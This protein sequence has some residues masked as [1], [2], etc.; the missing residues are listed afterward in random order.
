MA[1]NLTWAESQTKDW[2]KLSFDVHDVNPTLAADVVV[3]TIN[4]QYSAQKSY[5][6]RVLL[7]L[8]QNVD[9][10]AAESL[11]KT[12][13]TAEFILDGNNL[14]VLNQGKTFNEESLNS[15]CLGHISPKALHNTNI[16][17][18]SKGIGFRGTLNWSSDIRIYSGD[19]AVQFSSKRRSAQVE[20][21]KN[22]II[23]QHALRK[24]A[25]LVSKFPILL[26]PGNTNFPKEWT[27]GKYN[28]IY[29]TCIEII[30][31]TDVRQH[32][33][34]AIETFLTDEYYSVLFF[35]A[36][37]NIIFTYTDTNGNIVKKIIRTSTKQ[38][39]TPNHSIKTIEITSDTEDES[40]KKEFHFFRDGD[41]MIAV[42]VQWDTWRKKEYKLFCT[43]PTNAAFCPFP[44]LMNSYAFDVSSDRERLG[45]SSKN[46]TIIG[47]L[48][49]MLVNTVAPYYAN[50]QFG[51]Q[52]IE[53]LAYRDIEGTLFLRD[54]ENLYEQIAR[55]PIIPTLGNKYRR[56]ADGL[57]TMIHA[58]CP[59]VIIRGTQDDFISPNVYKIL[60]FAPAL[61]EMAPQI[62]P[63]DLYN[64]I[65][66]K[67]VNWSVQ[68][69]VSV[70]FF[71]VDK[72]DIFI[73]NRLMPKLIKNQKGDFYYFESA[74]HE[75][76]YFH[77]GETL[78]SLPG[79][80]PFQIVDATDQ[81]EMLTRIKSEELDIKKQIDRFFIK[82]YDYIF[83]HFDKA[84]V[85]DRINSCVNNNYEYAI[86]L[87]KFVYENYKNVSNPCGDE[88][89]S[90]N[91]PTASQTIASPDAVYFGTDYADTIGTKI[92]KAAGLNAMPSPKT[93]GISDENIENF[94]YTIGHFFGI[95]S[96]IIPV[97]KKLEYK[98]LPAPYRAH[99][100]TELGTKYERHSIGAIFTVEAVV[101]PG[102]D[103]ILK[104]ADQDTILEWLCTL[105]LNQT[106]YMNVDF[107][108]NRS[109]TRQESLILQNYTIYYLQNN[110]WLDVDDELR[111]PVNCLVRSKKI[112]YPESAKSLHY[113]PDDAKYGKL[114]DTLNIQDN[115]CH[116]PQDVFYEFLLELPELDTD[117]TVSKNIYRHIATTS[118]D[119]LKN[120]L[121]DERN[122]KKIEFLKSG[123]L[124]AKDRKS[125]QAKFWPV[126]NGVY[127]SSGKP[128]NITNK[129]IMETPPRNGSVAD[130]A[131][132]FGV[133]E[134]KENI[135]ACRNRSIKHNQ[136]DVFTQEFEHFKRYLLALGATKKLDN[137]LPNLEIMLV[138]DI[139][140][141][142]DTDGI[143]INFKNYEIVPT[144][145]ANK[146]FIYLDKNSTID[147]NQIARSIAEI[148]DAISAA[149]DI[150]DTIR[151]LYTSDDQ[152]REQILL[153]KGCDTTLLTEY[154]GT[155][156]LFIDAILAI[157]PDADIDLLLNENPINFDDF[158]AYDN[159]ESVIKIITALNTDVETFENNGFSYIN[160]TH[161]NKDLLNKYINA[162]MD[163][164]KT[165]C[166]NKLVGASPEEQ[167]KFTAMVNDFAGY[168]NDNIVPNIHDFDP[169]IFAP[170]PGTYTTIID[171]DALYDQNYKKLYQT[172]TDADALTE[173]LN[174]D[175]NISLLTFGN[176]Q[177]LT[178][179]YNEY[180][181]KRTHANIASN[182]TNNNAQ[183]G[184][185]LKIDQ[186]QAPKNLN[187]ATPPQSSSSSIG[188]GRHS[189]KRRHTAQS[190][191]Q[192]QAAGLRA[193]QHVYNALMK[194]FTNVQWISSNAEK[195]G[196][197]AKGKGDDR[198]GYDILY[199]DKDGK[200][201]YAEVKNATYAGDKKFTFLF[202][203]NEE[204]FARAN[205]H[206]YS[207]FMVVNDKKIKQISDNDLK[208]YLNKAQVETKKCTII[209]DDDDL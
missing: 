17:T 83:K 56:L 31:D 123:H 101:I 124:W 91:I 20:L 121:S 11:D 22:N 207:V 187:D 172:C 179:K 160:L 188:G 42:P 191:T 37:K 170:N 178:D 120:L 151:L 55:Q 138:Q 93:F 202:S 27:D 161:Y 45:V 14:R 34:D 95:R 66:Q 102:L 107:H 74:E 13:D 41:E 105:H 73:K 168:A 29:D 131:Y 192:K 28:G 195:A 77:S 167:E 10:A 135:V 205:I 145:G 86:D 149:G 159:A 199:K 43:F 137:A 177:A 64:I 50:P 96:N 119:L 162:N 3:S 197:L 144:E 92:C 152:N 68:E 134:F 80:T 166:Y 184:Q 53:M 51:T 61:Q 23:F 185:I 112:K 117:G 59:E 163:T 142:G 171:T 33:I 183:S 110:R 206:N 94:T 5:Q 85:A 132:I 24:S 47:K 16:V 89:V 133:K 62:T 201:K 189:G 82:K 182:T 30:L 128:L 36:L 146:Y 70:F 88:K 97:K 129:P 32:V 108:K 99:V 39:D 12:K 193:E 21:L 58:D 18:G 65:N 114:W 130:F 164:Y 1:Q 26:L 49:K 157:C 194:Q 104:N 106:D 103:T 60:E 186:H 139:K 84:D 115:V 52:A 126:S 63:E 19:F 67:S 198:K 8:L 109:G 6:A 69:R 78:K 136:N 7:E 196:I 143:K 25:D 100:D 180:I 2:I 158:G 35:R 169:K 118:N 190:D 176:I 113:V 155:R 54:I 116:L 57:K 209:L 72:L 173:I 175:S 154:R 165:Y 204:K 181:R 44:V 127:F 140:I 48:E 40:T 174:T 71:W 4:S 79:W 125:E 76:I 87:I 90:W 81:A 75:R 98:N 141:V 122:A 148:C 147:S 111:A 38:I 150:R 46:V 156:Q 153:D 200:I 203:T 9:D 15:I 208:F